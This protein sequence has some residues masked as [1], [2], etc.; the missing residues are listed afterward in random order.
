MGFKSDSEEREYTLQAGLIGQLYPALKDS[1]GRVIDGNTRLD[2]NPDWRVEV[3]ED[4]DTDRKYWAAK[5][6]ANTCRRVVPQEETAIDIKNLADAIVEEKGTTRGIIKQ[7]KEDTGLSEPYIRK[8]LRLAE[9][10][11]GAETGYISPSSEQEGETVIEPV[12]AV[13]APTSRMPDKSTFAFQTQVEQT[14]SRLVGLPL[15]S[16]IKRLDAAHDLSEEEARGYIERWKRDNSDF[17]GT[18]YNSKDEVKTT[19]SESV[20]EVKEEESTQSEDISEAPPAGLQFS[21][22]ELLIDAMKYYPDQIINTMWNKIGM[23]SKKLL[24]FQELFAVTY[25]M[26]L[27]TQSTESLMD[28]V[29]ARM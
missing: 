29:H 9:G 22:D 10:Q 8:L 23:D 4:I 12:E 26:A 11:T 7:I 24:F 19:P 1:R 3:R 14:I 6:G 28:I 18:L 5:I 15:D 13:I 20:P 27:E 2:E 17:W 16:I 21:K 25:E